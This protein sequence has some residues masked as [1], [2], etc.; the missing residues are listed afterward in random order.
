MPRG[1]QGAKHVQMVKLQTQEKRAARAVRKENFKARVQGTANS[2]RG[3][4]Q[5]NTT[6]PDAL[7]R[8]ERVSRASQAI[9]RAVT[10]VPWLMMNLPFSKLVQLV[11]T[12]LPVSFA[13]SPMPVDSSKPPPPQN[14]QI[15]HLGASTTRVPVNG[16]PSARDVNRVVWGLSGQGVVTEHLVRVVTGRPP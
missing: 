10:R 11:L 14:A 9:T 5:A 16:M 8:K 12:V 13:L 4:G 6:R 15:V 1:S 7:T 2:A 3:V